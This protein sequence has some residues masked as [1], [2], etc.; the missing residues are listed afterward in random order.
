MMGTSNSPHETLSRLNDLDD[1]AGA[2]AAPLL[3][4]LKAFQGGLV[5]GDEQHRRALV[6]AIGVLEPGAARHREVVELL[7][8]EALAVD[9]GV[10]ASLERRHQEARGLPQRTRP[11][12]RTQHLDEE[13]HGPKH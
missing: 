10:S 7:P 5:A 4:E 13:G 11:L 9:D 6:V 12:A 1:V 2:V 3:E 8:I